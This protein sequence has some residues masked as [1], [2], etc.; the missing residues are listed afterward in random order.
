MGESVD[1][2]KE[3]RIAAHAE[4]VAAVADELSEQY[5]R[6][7]ADRATLSGA[8]W[9]LLKAAAFSEDG[10]TLTISMTKSQYEGILALHRAC[11]PR[12]KRT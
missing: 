11:A 8:L 10:K 6:I 1:I 12:G 3:Q 5:E 2:N 4:R 9:N 7:R